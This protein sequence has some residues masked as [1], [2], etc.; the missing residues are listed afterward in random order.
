[1]NTIDG[2]EVLVEETAVADKRLGEVLRRT[3]H[4]CASID[5]ACRRNAPRRD[6]NQ[7]L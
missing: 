7:L 6:P 3:A 1:M 4:P 2:G 5:P